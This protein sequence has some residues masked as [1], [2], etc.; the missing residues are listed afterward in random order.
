MAEKSSNKN[1][2]IRSNVLQSTKFSLQL[3]ALV[4]LMAEVLIASLIV[5]LDPSNALFGFTL[6]IV[7]LVVGIVS[8]LVIMRQKIEE[9]EPYIIPYAGNVANA[10]TTKY[11]YDL[12][13]AS[14]M[15]SLDGKDFAEVNKR[16][17]NI[18]NIIEIRYNYR[19]F[20]AGSNMKTPDDFQ[21]ANL[22][23]REEIDALIQ[24]EKFM[25]IYPEKM[26]S[27]VIAEAGM[28]LALGKPSYYFGQTDNLP[29]LLKK[30][31]TDM[32]YK[33]IRLYEADSI[34]AAEKIIKYDKNKTILG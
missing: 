33:H 3:A 15:A 10:S 30:A 6:M 16:V 27:S 31:H 22:S 28:A 17:K 11:K 5:K 32:N 9:A 23:L 34:E 13:L 1:A 2:G 4:L 18:K 14:P 12:F 8:L 20:Y 25:M 19:V 29:F 7:V 26:V 24:S 21:N